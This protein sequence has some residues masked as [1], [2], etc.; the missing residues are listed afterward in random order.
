MNIIPEFGSLTSTLHGV[1]TDKLSGEWMK[2]DKSGKE[3]EEKGGDWFSL[4]VALKRQHLKIKVT[5]DD[6]HRFEIGQFVILEGEITV[7]ITKRGEVTTAEMKMVKINRFRVK[8]HASGEYIDVLLSIDEDDT[9][10][11]DP[12]AIKKARQRVRNS[13]A[14]KGK[15]GSEEGDASQFVA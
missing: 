2:R 13:L 1:V 8:D 11:L 5:P 7:G 3:T 6:F 10:A 9:P 4:S 12:E 14:G 15:P